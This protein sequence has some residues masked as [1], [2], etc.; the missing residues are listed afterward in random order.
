MA[1]WQDAGIW[2]PFPFTSRGT[3]NGTIA[4]TP[5]ARHEIVCS[6]LF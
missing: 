5:E 2:H 1:P 6:P 3:I 4:S